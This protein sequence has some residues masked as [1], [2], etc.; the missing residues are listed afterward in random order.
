M[1]VEEDNDDESLSLEF[2]DTE[3]SG[4][5]VQD[6][7]NHTAANMPTPKTAASSKTKK[8]SVTEVTA[9]LS[10]MTVKSAPH[11]VSDYSLNW[12]FPFQL[13][14]VVEVLK[15]II[16]ADFLCIKVLGKMAKVLRV[17]FQRFFQLAVLKWFY[18]E[19]YSR[20]QME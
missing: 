10:T 14:S 3:V 8:T 12:S 5:K 9:R 16:Y 7:H 4:S 11:Q 13:Y 18:E 1:E 15:E 2:K 6:S 17:G 19:F 20:K